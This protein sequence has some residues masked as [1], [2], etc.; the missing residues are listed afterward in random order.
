[1]EKQ[2]E[3][4]EFKIRDEA[5]LESLLISKPEQI[6]KDFIVLSNQRS[7]SQQ[8]RLDIIGVDINGTLTIIELKVVTD[9]MQLSQSL[10]Y[11]SWVMEQGLDWFS[12]AYKEKLKNRT[13]EDNMPQIFLIAPD[14]TSNLKNEI[15]FIRKDITVRLF[16]YIPIEIE[17]AKFI[18]LIEERI[19]PL[20]EIM[21]KPWKLSDNL[22]YISNDEIKKLFK[23]STEKV[24][25]FEK[26]KIEEK[27]GKLVISYWI[28]GLKFCEFYPKK[29][30]FAVGYKTDEL[31]T[32]WTWQTEIADEK[33]FDDLMNTKLKY[34]F[35]LMKSK[36]G[37]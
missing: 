21:E 36:K 9:P 22:S 34:A 6:E 24:K 7:T 19:E 26:E 3:L 33:I 28:N 31:D 4:K 10:E 14:F 27:I 1:M 13:I 17:N 15:K 37:K 8:K 18:K 20:K 12:N 2:M 25:T 32:G 29:E 23:E 5:E 16:R 11:Y 35:N 30:Y